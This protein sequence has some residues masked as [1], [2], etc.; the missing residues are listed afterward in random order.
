MTRPINCRIWVT[1]S[2]VG[3]E[4]EGFEWR[5]LRRTE[6]SD[7]WRC[8]VDN[9]RGQQRDEKKA[10]SQHYVSLSRGWVSTKNLNLVM[11][12]KKKD[13]YY[14]EIVIYLESLRLSLAVL[15]EQN[16]DLRVRPSIGW[17]TEE[18]K[19]EYGGG[20]GKRRN[21]TNSIKNGLEKSSV[22]YFSHGGSHRC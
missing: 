16:T 15:R 8:S 13:H 22:P 19:R 4:R 21:S 17:C 14:G 6:R 10:T 20:S 11:K 5:D 9:I 12:K 18:F 3:K 1:I 7:A 2:C